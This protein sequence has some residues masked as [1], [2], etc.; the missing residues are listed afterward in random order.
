MGRSHICS[1]TGINHHTRNKRSKENK[2]RSQCTTYLLSKDLA[3]ISK[4]S[5][6]THVIGAARPW[7]LEGEFVFF[8]NVNK[9]RTFLHV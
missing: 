4:S 3:V 9:R 2:L 5:H 6:A 1:R 8:E 7:S